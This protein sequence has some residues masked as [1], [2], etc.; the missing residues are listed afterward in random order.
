MHLSVTEIFILEMNFHILGDFLLCNKQKWV[1]SPLHAPNSTRENK[2][3]NQQLM[4]I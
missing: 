1:S 4:P 2:T 3:Q